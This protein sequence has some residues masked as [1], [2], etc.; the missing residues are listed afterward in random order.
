MSAFARPN[1]VRQTLITDTL[2][3]FVYVT[4]VTGPIFVG[5]KSETRLR[6]YFFFF[7]EENGPLGRPRLRW[8]DDIKMD[9]REV[10]WEGIWPGVRTSGGLV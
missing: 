3:A 4:T 6:W 10:D 5:A 9:L 1:L 2:N 8:E 7:T